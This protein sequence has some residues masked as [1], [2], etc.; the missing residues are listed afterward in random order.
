MPACACRTRLRKLPDE[1]DSALAQ[2]QFDRLVGFV[3]LLIYVLYTQHRYYSLSDIHDLKARINKMG[4]EY[5]GKRP[6]AGL[7]SGG[8]GLGLPNRRTR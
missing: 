5:V 1:N 2:A 7:V 8:V 4:S 6:N 3:A